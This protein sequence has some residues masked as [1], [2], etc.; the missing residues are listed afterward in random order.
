[1]RPAFR[2]RTICSENNYDLTIIFCLFLLSNISNTQK[3]E[4]KITIFLRTKWIFSYTPIVIKKLLLSK[5]V[6]VRHRSYTP[7]PYPIVLLFCICK[8]VKMNFPEKFMFISFAVC[9]KNRFENR[10]KSWQWT[11]LRMSS[12]RGLSHHQN[13]FFL[14]N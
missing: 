5:N 9:E 11:F 12:F 10:R 8:D 1:M 2:R 13:C 3:R 4:L 7:P 6:H 14:R